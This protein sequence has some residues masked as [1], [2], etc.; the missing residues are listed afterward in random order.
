MDEI[1]PYKIHVDESSMELLQKKLDIVTFPNEGAV[2]DNWAY[3]A[4]LCDI[5]RLVSRWRQGFDWRTQETKLNELPQFTTNVSVGGFGELNI[6][7]IHKRSSQP[8]AIPLLFVHGWPGSF[9]EVLKILPLLTEPA[10]GQAFHVV[11]PSLPNHGFSA[12]VTSPGFALPQY[13]EAMHK[14]MV[15]LDYSQ[16]VTQGGDWGYHITR[17]IGLLYPTSCLASHVNFVSL[18]EKPQSLQNRENPSALPSIPLEYSEEEK[19]GLQRTK[20]FVEEGEGY[21]AEQSTRPTT[22]A[23]ALRDSPVALLAWI[24]EKLHDWTDSYP[25]EDDEVLTWVS[26]YQFSRA[27]PQ[28]SLYLY[29]ES[30]RVEQQRFREALRQYVHGVPLGV[31]L[32]PKDL[33]I[34][35]DSWIREMGPVIFLNRQTSGGHFAAYERPEGLV[36]DVREMFRREGPLEDVIKLFH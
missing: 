13:A 17:H 28:S 36:Q 6:H 29:Y 25:W 3:G 19:A 11:A 8:G 26:I 35:P 33:K 15:R 12:E 21:K 1:I 32:F 7:F 34:P 23:F 16:Y 30:E 18:V 2:S 20:W 22:L 27:G 10:N 24:Y 14:I 5:K 4:P 9:L 31:S